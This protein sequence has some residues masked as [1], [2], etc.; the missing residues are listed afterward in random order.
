MV[1]LKNQGNWS[2]KW[3]KKSDIKVRGRKWYTKS[4]VKVTGARSGVKSLDI[5]VRGRKWYKKIYFKKRTS[6]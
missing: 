3:H 5:K 4:D 6:R 1:V 2:Q